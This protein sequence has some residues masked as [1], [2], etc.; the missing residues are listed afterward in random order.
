MFF[1]LRVNLIYDLSVVLSLMFYNHKTTFPGERAG[2]DSQCQF[3][4][5]CL[6]LSKVLG[7]FP[8]NCEKNTFSITEN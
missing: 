3:P 2:E 8:F 7:V 4:L 5:V 1:M 6:N